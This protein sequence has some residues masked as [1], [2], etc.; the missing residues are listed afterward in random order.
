MRMSRSL[1]VAAGY[2]PERYC[3]NCLWV[4]DYVGRRVCFHGGD[5]GRSIQGDED[6]TFC[7]DYEE[8]ER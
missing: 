8:A 6:A 4:R 3:V 5:V 1:E 2:K 7:E